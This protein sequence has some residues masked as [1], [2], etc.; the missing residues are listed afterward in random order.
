MI[1]IKIG[2]NGHMPIRAKAQLR[3]MYI[4]F[5]RNNLVFDDYALL[6]PDKGGNIETGAKIKKHI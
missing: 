5:V 1:R 4:I 3:L 2:L 6:W